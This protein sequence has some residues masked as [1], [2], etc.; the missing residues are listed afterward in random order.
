MKHHRT[1]QELET[2][3][4]DAAHARRATL[5]RLAP[6]YPVGD[7][8]PRASDAHARR[9]GPGVLTQAI[10]LLGLGGATT[11]GLL[12]LVTLIGLVMSPDPGRSST[13]VAEIDLE[14]PAE[15]TLPS[16]YTLA[17]NLGQIEAR[18]EQQ[19]GPSVNLATAWPARLQDLP[20]AFLEADEELQKPFEIELTA[21]RADLETAARY[22]RQRWTA[23]PNPDPAGASI[24]PE[25]SPLTG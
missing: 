6:S 16:V 8:P 15:T 22:L 19:L 10:W 1:P 2:Q 11:A 14:S 12:G 24:Y 3:L 4:R 21:I 25:L 9:A 18:M 13:P 7:Y 5:D 17:A 23:P 20:E